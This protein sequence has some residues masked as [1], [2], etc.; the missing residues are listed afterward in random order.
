MTAMS[1]SSPSYPDF[2]IL[3]FLWVMVL[4][5]TERVKRFTLWRI[6]TLLL[7]SSEQSGQD[8]MPAYF[9]GIDSESLLSHALDMWAGHCI[10]HSTKEVSTT[11]GDS[12]LVLGMRSGHCDSYLAGHWILTKYY[13]V[14]WLY[15]QPQNEDA[16]FRPARH[17]HSTFRLLWH[18]TTATFWPSNV[19][20][21]WHLSL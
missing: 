10:L 16:T 6:V 15:G 17:V 9:L 8:I 3:A 14:P 20:L 2:H 19:L 18:L 4:R 1:C 7:I 5:R 21:L 12:Y 13:G 11:L